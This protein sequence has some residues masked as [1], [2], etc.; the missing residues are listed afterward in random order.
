M[1]SPIVVRPAAPV[2]VPIP[3][4]QLWPY[5]VFVGAL[6]FLLLYFVVAEQGAVALIGGT[7]VH[8]LV[9]DARHLVGVPCH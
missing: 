5:V 7:M 6:L 2:L 9:H 8:E 4:R 1:A 3:I